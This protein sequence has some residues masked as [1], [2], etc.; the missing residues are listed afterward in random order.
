MSPIVLASGSPR[1]QEYF[2]LLGLPFT[3]LN[4]NIDENLPT[5]TDPQ[6]LTAELAVKKVE[7][8]IELLK[9]NPPEWICGADTVVALNNKI[10]GKP[11]DCKEAAEMLLALSGRQHE[12][13]TSVALYSKN[14]GKIDCR[15]ASC[16]VSFAPLSPAEIKWYLG[17][18]EWQGAAG[19][20]RLQG[21]ASCFIT[22]ISGAPSTVVGLPLQEF[23][24][25]LRKNNYPYGGSLNCNLC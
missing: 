16:L 25:M 13:F 23:Y 8:A 20:Y 4:T 12:V 2:Q 14:H 1:R 18:N 24:D 7:A 3:V 19:A 6:K 9:E 22:K 15:S 21:L 5:Q 11:E 10:Y 17:K